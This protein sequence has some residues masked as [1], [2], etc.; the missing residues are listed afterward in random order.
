M[1]MQK[2]RDI[3]FNTIGLLANIENAIAEKMQAGQADEARFGL[4]AKLANATPPVNDAFQRALGASIQAELVKNAEAF[5]W[6]KFTNAFWQ[7]FNVRRLTLVGSASLLVV[8]LAFAI[9]SSLPKSDED[10]YLPPVEPAAQLASND[11]D[12]LV[13]KLNEGS[14]PRAVIVYP[15]DYA[16]LL[17]EHVQQQVLPLTL[18]EDLA[19][20]S[21]QAALDRILPSSGL[22]EAVLVNQEGADTDRPVRVA[23]ER[24]LFR[25]DNAETFGELERN[26]YVVG[27]E[28]VVLKPIGALFESGIELMAVGLFDDLH[29]GA[30][31]RLAFDWRVTEPIEDSLVM[32]AH[33]TREGRP[34]AQRDAVPG[35]GLFPVENWEVGEV[36]RDQKAILLPQELPA[37]MYELRVGIYSAT[38]G[39]RYNLIGAVD[40][41]YV[42]IGQ[43]TVIPSTQADKET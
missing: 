24:T 38:T 1:N 4:P 9:F 14:T 41:T 15:P 3:F 6:R 37:G 23:L 26:P 10:G 31:L 19:P 34:L 30:P 33:L 20:A 22:V 40:A 5:G 13:T 8:I 28:E 18:S 43:F 29:P 32:F 36:V 42:V 12:G 16:S 7:T 17:G 35:N 2:D 25:L 21:I 11:I 27:P 39:Q